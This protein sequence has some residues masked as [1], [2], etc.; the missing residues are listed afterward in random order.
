[1]HNL[2]LTYEDQGKLQEA[3]ALMEETADLRKQA[4]GVWHVYTRNSLREL[5]GIQRRIQSELV[6]EPPPCAM[7][8][9]ELI[10]RDKILDDSQ[11]CEHPNIP[12]A[13]NPF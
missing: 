8:T 12:I 9:N 2:A 1:M 4:L 7:W 3:E 10:F 13:L 5:E 11:P 6:I